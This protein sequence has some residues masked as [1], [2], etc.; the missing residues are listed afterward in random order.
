MLSASSRPQ[1]V[2]SPTPPCASETVMQCIV[3]MEYKNEAGWQYDG[4]LG[5]YQT[6]SWQYESHDEEQGEPRGGEEGS[7]PGRK[8]AQR[9]P[10]P[11]ELQRLADYVS[12]GGPQK[13]EKQA[14]SDVFWEL[15]NSSEFLMKH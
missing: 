8:E 12:S 2:P 13:D 9:K 6:D 10:R 14:L 4:F 5:T 15:L 3:E 11:D 7:S 1:Q